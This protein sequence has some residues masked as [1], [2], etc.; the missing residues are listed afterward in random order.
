MEVNGMRN[1]AQ[2][3]LRGINVLQKRLVELIDE[4]DLRDGEVLKVSQALDGLINDFSRYQDSRI[5][6]NRLAEHM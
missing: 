2:E 1:E 5:M 4:K 6:E 3:I